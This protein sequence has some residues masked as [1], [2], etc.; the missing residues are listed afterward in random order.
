MYAVLILK[1][2]TI[3]LYSINIDL[4]TNIAV[5]IL[6]VVEKENFPSVS[7]AIN[8]NIVSIPRLETILFTNVDM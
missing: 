6:S 8:I 2:V 1:H 7:E 4:I 3:F 5:I